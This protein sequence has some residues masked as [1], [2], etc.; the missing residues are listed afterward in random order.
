MEEGTTGERPWVRLL[1]RNGTTYQGGDRVCLDSMDERTRRY[2]RTVREI[3]D[4]NTMGIDVSEYLVE[5]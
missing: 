5:F 4:P 1:V 2:R 3:V